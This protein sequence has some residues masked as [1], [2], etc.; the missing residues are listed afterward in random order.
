MGSEAVRARAERARRI[1][2]G[3]AIV[4]MAEERIQARRNIAAQGSLTFRSPEDALAWWGAATMRMGGPQG[5]HPR[6]ET[7]R[8]GSQVHVSVDG[9]RGGDLAEVHATTMDIEAA[10]DALAVIPDEVAYAGPAVGI[11]GRAAARMA[12]HTR[13][14]KGRPP[15]VP[16]SA[17][18]QLLVDHIVG[19]VTLE[20]LAK[21][22]GVSVSTAS[23]H[24]GIA[25]R[26]LEAGLEGVVVR[27]VA[28]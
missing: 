17:Y 12:Q 19:G 7:A 23:A 2:K 20:T 27:V 13:P 16:R 28:T 14:G 1:A 3:E 4:A 11:V 8:D 5:M 18:R 24:V 15:A 10:L 25:L 21:G 22:L 26:L 9:G 6:T